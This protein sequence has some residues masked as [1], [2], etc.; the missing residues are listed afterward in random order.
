MR[1]SLGGFRTFQ[2]VLYLIAV[3]ALCLTSL[4]IYGFSIFQ[5]IGVYLSLWHM[6]KFIP[7]RPRP[8][9]GEL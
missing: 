3:M 2:L 5:V 1:S 7:Y 8:P 4:L 6:E 9:K